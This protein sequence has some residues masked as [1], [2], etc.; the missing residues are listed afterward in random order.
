MTAF[1]IVYII[2]NI[3]Y[4]FTNDK[5]IKFMFSESECDK[6]RKNIILALYFI[7]IS[8]MIF[9]TRVPVIILIINIIFLFLMT[10]C[11]D[12]S[13]QRKIIAI[14]L[15]YSTGL[16]IELLSLATFGF[17]EFSGLKNATNNS[18]TVLI[19]A[20]MF[21]FSFVYLI[22]R[23]KGSLMKNHNI[24]K[25]YYLTFATILFGTLY[26]F[27]SQLENENISINRILISG[28]VLIIVNIT[29]IVIDEKIY[30]SILADNEKNLLKQ[31]NIA[32]ENQMEL[33]SQSTEEIRMIK[34]DFKN[35]L[36]MLLNLYNSGKKEQLEEYINKILGNIEND[37]VSNSNNFVID[38]ILNFKLRSIVNTDIKINLEINVPVSVN[39]F[40]YDLT[41]VLSNLLDNAI[42]AC[43]KSDDKV[44]N[45]KISSKLD[46]LIIFISNSY[47]GKIIC[48]NGEFKTTKSFKSEHG[49]GIKSIEKIV[50]NY[51]GEM[52]ISYTA[53]MFSTTI[54]IPYM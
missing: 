38:S 23:F 51:D 6:K 1:Q 37:A 45:I 11:Y 22:T 30:N 8:G 42:T 17:F 7:S 2:T 54:L 36:N 33:I 53:N 19:F 10:F 14:V 40:A 50:K 49:I 44:L 4:I 13:I 34:H 12:S 5:I 9:V 24:P 16:V 28:F 48:E 3:L 39:I 27:L 35:H 46:N 41:C 29:M 52:K 47:D 20:R 25:I 26:L 32:Y 31:Q 21:T 43:K 18:V 15:V